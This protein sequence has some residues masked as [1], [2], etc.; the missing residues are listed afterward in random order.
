LLGLIIY[1]FNGMGSSK[2][3]KKVL[4]TLLQQKIFPDDEDAIVCF[5]DFGR[6]GRPS[7]KIVAANLTRSQLEL[8]SPDD[9]PDVDVANAV[10]ASISLPMIFHLPRIVMPETRRSRKNR[11]RGLMAANRTLPTGQLNQANR[12][13]RPLRLKEQPRRELTSRLLRRM[14]SRPL[15]GALLRALWR[16]RGRRELLR[17]KRRPHGDLFTDGGIVSNLPAWCFDEERAIDPDA[18]TIIVDIPEAPR[19]LGPGRLTWLGALIQT[20]FFGGVELNLRGFGGAL[21]IPLPTS[22]EV[23]EFDIRMDRVATAVVEAQT[24]SES[25]IRQHREHRDRVK[26]TCDWFR[27]EASAR[28]SMVLGGET[29]LIRAAVAIPDDGYTRSLRLVHCSGFD[30]MADHSVLLPIEGSVAGL[31]WRSRD[32]QFESSPDKL[33]LSGAE[34]VRLRRLIHPGLKWVYGVPISTTQSSEPDIVVLLDGDKAFEGDPMVFFDE[35]REV[36][37]SA[38]AAPV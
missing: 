38:F 10:G 28:L 37:V 5:R 14:R 32:H 19:G 9:T 8:F 15:L 21:N 30:D 2:P 36:A 27:E 18:H 20:G 35:L 22:I 34:N 24:Y 33:K 7:L 3:L 17:G 4:N 29:G 16:D 13:K 25:L 26:A 1:V 23:L 31:A 6:N 11:L 12:L